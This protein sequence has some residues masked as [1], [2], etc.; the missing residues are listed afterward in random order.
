MTM[1]AHLLRVPEVSR[2]LG[3]EGAEVYALIDHGELRASKGQDGLVY[4]A[5]Q[6]VENDLQGRSAAPH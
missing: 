3:I 4:V 2:V 5:E 6:A 1:S